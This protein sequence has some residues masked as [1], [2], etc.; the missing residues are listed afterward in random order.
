MQ[1]L[2]VE[3]RKAE[4]ENRTLKGHAAV[5]D[6]ET[7]IGSYWER[8]ERGAFKEA[9]DRGDDVRALFNHDD[10]KLLGRRSS[11]TL[12]MRETDHGLEVEIDLPDTTLGNDV[13]ELVRRGDITGMSFGFVPG[14]EEWETRDGE[15][16][17][18]HRSIAKLIDVSPV[19]FPAYE[20]TDVQI[21]KREVEVMAEEKRAMSVEELVAALE[22]IIAKA[23]DDETGEDR[24]LNEEEQARYEE[25]ERQLELIRKS[26]EIRSRHEA[27]RKVER[28][29][30]A[31]T[32]VNERENEFRNYLVNPES[33]GQVIG[34]PSAGGYAVPESWA[35]ELVRQIETYGGLASAVRTVNTSTGEPL[36]YTVRKLDQNK[37]EI[38]AEATAPLTGA[39]LVFDQVSLGAYAYQ[40][41]GANGDPFRVSR[42]LLQDSMFDI[43]GEL[44]SVAAERISRALA[45]D[46]VA[47]SGSGEPEGITESAGP[48]AEFE[49]DAPSYEELV[50]A[51]HKIDPAY[52]RGS[53]WVFNDATL[54][55]I[56][57]LTDE[58]GRPLLENATQGIA[59][60][61]SAT[62]LGF[63][64]V[65]DQAFDDFEDGSEKCW[66]VF[67]NL[68]EGYILRRVMN[69]EVLA[70]PYTAISTR[71][72]LY[73]AW[74]RF[75]GKIRNPLAFALLVNDDTAGSESS[76]E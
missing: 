52:R 2:P 69:V 35:N 24:P 14:D 36:H 54:A 10:D 25:L 62:L 40:S 38:V 13:L 64:V 3:L 57:K 34:T 6:Q 42:E 60:G 43:A 70:D 21:R 58:N 30:V 49:G 23:K 63:P 17:R 74:A 48:V 53:V 66:G 15:Q 32:E 5:F 22:D 39:D 20:G 71:E 8:I 16:I 46:L 56:R 27:A 51:V 4:T 18:V 33:R 19:T 72:V 9:I 41:N 7:R 31:R 29:M 50:A 28:P 11:G 59:D 45:D 68:R 55:A 26:E 73:T 67:G 47:G 1:R 61:M 76:S 12:R 75:D 44:A 65:V 37:A